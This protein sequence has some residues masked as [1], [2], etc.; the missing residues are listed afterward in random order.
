MQAPKFTIEKLWKAIRLQLVHVI[1]T[2][3]GNERFGFLVGHL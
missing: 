1:E 2:K 3:N